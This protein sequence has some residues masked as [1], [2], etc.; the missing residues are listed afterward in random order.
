MLK[1]KSAD[2]K[3]ETRPINAKSLSTNETKLKTQLFSN[4]ETAESD[5]Q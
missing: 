1:R 2:K 5:S 4:Q 3:K